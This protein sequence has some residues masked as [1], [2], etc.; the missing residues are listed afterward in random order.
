[1]LPLEDVD[2]GYHVEEEAEAGVMDSLE[3]PRAANALAL[4]ACPE[5]VQWSIICDEIGEKGGVALVN[6][7]RHAFI[8]SLEGSIQELV[9]E[10]KLQFAQTCRCHA[11]ADVVFIHVGVASDLVAR[12]QGR[13]KY[14]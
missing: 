3:V 5:Q 12:S 4:L 9:R 10:L 7:L 2:Y 8:K 11:S 6:V 1:M 13:S 14:P